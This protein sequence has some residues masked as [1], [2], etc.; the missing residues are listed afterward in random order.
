MLEERKI[1]IFSLSAFLTYI[2]AFLTC[3]WDMAY[4]YFLLPTFILL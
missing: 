3:G 1:F 2:C 4:L